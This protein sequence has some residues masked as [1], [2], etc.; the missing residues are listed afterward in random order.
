MLTDPIRGR[1]H[2]YIV[3]ILKHLESPSIITNSVTDH[4]HILFLLS[5][6]RSL[7][8]VIEEVKRSSSK[9]VKGIAPDL[10]SFYWQTG[11][12]AFSV[13]QYETERAIRYI[14]NQ[15]IH[16]QTVSF[17]DELRALCLEAGVMLNESE[18]WD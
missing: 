2:G 16:H 18:C 5:K 17:Q 3:G 1:V 11:Y 7:V 9:F 4:I 6:M 15:Q 12:G 14:R 13:G 8:D 10:T